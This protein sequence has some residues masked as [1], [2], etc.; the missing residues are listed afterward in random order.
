MLKVTRSCLW[1]GCCCAASAVLFEEGGCEP[2]LAI[3]AG[4]GGVCLHSQSMHQHHEL[5]HSH[6]D[7]RTQP[8]CLS[9]WVLRGGRTLKYNNG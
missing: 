4:S 6:R 7:D 8:T 2:D 1:P 5:S 9:C 3:A